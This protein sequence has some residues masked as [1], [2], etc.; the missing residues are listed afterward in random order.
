MVLG[1]MDA[2]KNSMVYVT[3]P[4]T[5]G[6]NTPDLFIYGVN[7]NVSAW[8]NKQAAFAASEG[9][10]GLGRHF[11]SVLDCNS[12]LW[13]GQRVVPVAGSE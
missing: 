7:E 11:Q 10:P 12:S 8:A 6:P 5:Q 9:G 3:T 4:M 1:S 2:Y 13:M